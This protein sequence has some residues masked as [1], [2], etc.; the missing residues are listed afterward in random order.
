[1]LLY[2]C[3]FVVLFEKGDCGKDHSGSYC[4]TETQN[5]SSGL[6]NRTHETLGSYTIL[7]SIRLLSL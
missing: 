1:M 4:N 3:T 6:T 7:V 2:T 5:W